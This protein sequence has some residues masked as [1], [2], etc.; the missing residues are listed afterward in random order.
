MSKTTWWDLRS[1][2]MGAKR[3]LERA[4]AAR[5]R[6]SRTIPVAEGLESRCLLAVMITE[7]PIPSPGSQPQEITTGPDGNLWFAESL[8]N[9]I[10]SINPTTH[11]FTEF[12]VPTAASF[13]LGIATGSD[14]NIWFTESSG[15]VNQIGQF[16]PT[17]HVFAE[18]P[19]PHPVSGPFEMTAGPDGDLWFAE[20]GG[21]RIGHINPTTHAIVE[22]GTNVGQA[23]S[24]PFGIGVGPDG[25]IWF[26]EPN[27]RRIG[28][29]N[30]ATS[31]VTEFILSNVGAGPLG[32]TG[33]PDGNV[34]FTEQ[35][36]DKIGRI[37]PTTHVIT[38]FPLRGGTAPHD[39]TNPGDGN[40]WFTE[41]GGTAGNMIASINA[42]THAVTEFP[43]PTAHS[44]PFGITTGP[45][46][47]IWFGEVTGNQIGQAVIPH[48]QFAT[49]THLDSA[50]NPSTFGQQVTFTAT[51]TTDSEVAPTGDVTFTIDGVA[52]TPAV[53]LVLVGGNEQA[54]FPI[55]T[56]SPGSH[57][58]TAVYN[59]NSNLAPSPPS[60]IV[61][62]V[63]KSN[64]V[65]SFTHLDAT[66]NPS[67]FG[68][69]VT[70]TATVTSDTEF[71]PTGDVTFTIDGVAQT[72]P[73]PLVVIGGKVEAIF[74]T[75]TLSPGSHKVTAVYN[76][77]SNL[78]PST[79]NT[80]TQVV[81]A[82]EGGPQILAVR[83]FGF[84]ELPTTLV[85]VFNQPL[86][87]GTAQ[88]PAAYRIT[89]PHGRV[90]V[91]NSAVYNPTT[92]TVTLHPLER[93]N[94]HLR[95]RLTVFGT[96][97]NAVK[98]TAG[99]RLDGANN[100]HSGTNF[101][102]FVTIKN[103]VRPDPDGD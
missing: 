44:T 28:V 15:S 2:G 59:G 56:L 13:P 48:N 90:I 85:L 29:V 93:L 60:N 45:D 64:K 53:P 75:S 95:Y 17:T 54:K 27:N 81:N 87:P 7:F 80:V 43:V 26:T 46:R 19:L 68:Q 35:G 82:L 14:G 50:P 39:I 92:R 47:N 23:G 103:W 16:N 78:N 91:I 10:A 88:N 24:G 97:P 21:N 33:G 55:S 67:N 76:G 42:T 3:R 18:F 83:R 4:S 86:D 69:Q 57:Q 9:K 96:G 99:V 70:F 100:G 73:V 8:A 89:D 74:E 62:Q 40:L 65:V 58:V 52:Q 22:V 63:V 37:N 32:I 1:S 94:L 6:R 49:S 31:A 72:P 84:H 34:W 51:V 25:N 61:T 20:S 79:S 98:N 101:V 77:N 11:A 36:T 66:P 38:E 5:T 41:A 102:T 30:V 71:V 12:T